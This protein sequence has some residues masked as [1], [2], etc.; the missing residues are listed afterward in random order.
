MILGLRS[1]CL[2]IVLNFVNSFQ[3]L[4]Q[5]FTPALFRKIQQGHLH[6]QI[7]MS[8]SDRNL[9]ELSVNVGPTGNVPGRVEVY[10]TLGCK[11]CRMAKFKLDELGVTYHNV[12]I[13]MPADAV[14]DVKRQQ[15]R[16]EDARERT[17]P[18]I[19]VGEEY[20][21]GCDKLM[22][23]IDN[24]IFFDRLSRHDIVASVSDSAATTPILHSRTSSSVK[25]MEKIDELPDKIKR[26][27]VLNS[28]RNEIQSEVESPTECKES[29]PVKRLAPLELSSAL[30][31]QALRLTDKFAS[32]DGSRVDYKKM[33]I[34]TEFEDYILL[35]ESLQ[36]CT[37]DE[38]SNLSAQKRLSFFANL[39]NAMIIHATCILVSTI[40]NMCSQPKT[41]SQG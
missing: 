22:I 16:V 24:G 28:V 23:E 40:Q 29:S 10:S 41:F 26:E 7:K 20:I 37:L 18:Q 21:G 39:Y 13:T 9:G 17:V 11:F 15:K 5:H 2:I 31:L 12:D 27:G 38:L 30:Q 8:A 36:L 3:V 32:M 33:K 25:M 34:S 4:N 6:Q 19:Y 14:V 35:S 1:I